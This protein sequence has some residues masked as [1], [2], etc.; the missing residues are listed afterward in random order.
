MDLNTEGQTHHTQSREAEKSV[1]LNAEDMFPRPKPDRNFLNR[2]RERRR[3]LIV[4]DPVKCTGC[5]TCEMICSSRNGSP[6]VPSSASIRVIRDER[7][8][9]NFA[10]YCQQCREPFCME[11]C[12]T[13]AIA[14]GKDG[15]V[16]IDD[17]RCVD[18]ALCAMAC[19]EAAPLIDPISS[20]VHKCDLCEG[21]PLCV[22]HCTEQALVFTGGK[23]FGWIRLLR[24][25]VQL[26]AFLLL[27]VILIGS[28]CSFVAGAFQLSCP[29]GVLQNI[30]STRMLILVSAIAAIP[31]MLL[32][33]LGGRF[34]CGW[35]CPFGF[36]LDL[37]DKV[38]VRRLRLPGFLRARSAKYG[39][40]AA[41][42]GGSYALAYQAF[43]TVCPIGTLCRAHGVQGV[44]KGYELAILPAV[45]SLEIGDRRSWCRYYCP[46]GALLALA[47]RIGLIKIVIGAR[48]CKK[49]SCMR[50]ADIC[51]MGIVD[52]DQLIEGI[53]PRLPMDECIFCMRC[54]DQ[55]PYSAVKI[56]FRWQ[57]AASGEQV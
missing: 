9:K 51:P 31:L 18:C 2:I 19:P 27:V 52:R 24:W 20:K 37:I 36:F 25:P 12:P 11:V 34:F 1:F 21:E 43:C 57:K 16:R 48:K 14:R 26:S 15:I 32:T 35:L 10:I 40:L 22:A 5:G 42:I 33:V 55:C 41:S 17:I 3:P 54:I 28:F 23:R 13:Q 44:F 56:R 4:F 46:V 30:A 39:V 47:A 7:Y 45:A 6:V 29:L 8:G 50:C 49:F 38:I 53:S